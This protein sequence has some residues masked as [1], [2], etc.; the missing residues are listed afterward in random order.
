MGL[1]FNPQL[2]QIKIKIPRTWRRDSYSI[3][4]KFSGILVRGVWWSVHRDRTYPD[5]RLTLA[6][7]TAIACNWGS[8]APANGW[9]VCNPLPNICNWGLTTRNSWRLWALLLHKGKKRSRNLKILLA[10]YATGVGFTS[11]RTL[12]CANKLHGK[13]W[14]WCP[15][16]DPL[17]QEFRLVDTTSHSLYWYTL[18]LGYVALLEVLTTGALSECQLDSRA[19]MLSARC[20]GEK[21]FAVIPLPTLCWPTQVKFVQVLFLAKINRASRDSPTNR[22][23]TKTKKQIK[24]LNT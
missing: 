2:R 19:C 18:M 5:T 6:N 10:Q 23:I 15:G 17:D 22:T 1:F 12:R 9:P 11:I 8:G 14:H 3:Q 13:P 24:N 16:A 4:P 20:H 21:V 7:W